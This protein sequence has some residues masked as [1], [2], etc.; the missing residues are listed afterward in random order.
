MKLT[1][2]DI[3]NFVKIRIAIS[4]AISSIVGYTLATNSM[5]WD[6]V[7]LFFSVLLLAAGSASLNQVQ[8]WR[9]DSLM[10]RTKNRLIPL[11]KI[12]NKEGL[13]FSI[14]LLSLGLLIVF[15]KGIWGSNFLPFYLGILAILFYNVVYTPLKRITPYAALPGALIGAI[16]P[17]IGWTFA[18]GDLFN[19][20][21]LFL[22]LFFFVWQMPH[23]WL[24]LIIYEEDYRRA[25]YPLI[26]DKLSKQQLSRISFFWII[27]LVIIAFLIPI[28]GH[29]SNV[30][31]FFIMF[32]I[33]MYLVVRSI[34]L[35]KIVQLPIEYYRF[36]FLQLNFFV[37]LVSLIITFNK[38]LNL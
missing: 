25:G 24:L 35:V 28:S 5:D 36:T 29:Q 15:S 19:P 26:T 32:L 33:G 22:S 9:Y 3:L 30:L 34:K 2:S 7:L 1:I 4:V 17:A 12:S 23:F 16:P 27:S 31:T 18:S 8:E 20:Q 11:E 13:L 10:L 21:I 6:V 14:I 37:L 38:F